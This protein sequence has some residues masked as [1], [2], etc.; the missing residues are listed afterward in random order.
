MDDLGDLHQFCPQVAP[1]FRESRAVRDD[2]ADVISPARVPTSTASSGTVLALVVALAVGI[3]GGV[4]LAF[5][6]EHLD[7]TVRSAADLEE[8]AGLAA[9]A[10]IPA[11]RGGRRRIAAPRP[12]LLAGGAGL[13]H[14]AGFASSPPTG[15]LRRRRRR[16]CLDKAPFPTK[17][18]GNVGKSPAVPEVPLHMSTPRRRW[19]L[20]LLL[21]P[22]LLGAAACGDDGDSSDDASGDSSETSTDVPALRLGYFPNLTHAPALVGVEQGIFEDALEGE[23]TL[24]T[25]TF[26]AG[27]EAVEALFADALDATFIGPNPAINA[28]AQSDGAAVRIISGSTS[29]GAYLVVRDG[30]DAPEDLAGTT[31]A[32]PQLGNTQDVALRSW[33]KDEGYATDEAGGGD[34]SIEPQANGDAL[35]AFVAGDIDGAWVPEPWATRMVQEGSGHVLVDEG[36]LWPEGK[37]VTTHLIVRTEYLEENPEAVKAL[38]DGTVDAIDAANDDPEAAKE[39]AN[40]QLE[41][42]TDKPLDDAVIDA[43]WENLTFT[44]DPIATSLQKGAEDAEAVGLLDPVDLD[45]IYDLGPL[46]EVLTDK[47]Q[48]AVEDL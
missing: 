1:T 31:L 26:N 14:P 40:A 10:T 20:A 15:P 6:R 3:V 22:A 5:L 33:L 37:Y 43:A 47:G 32:S 36:D 23:A 11:A 7:D 16:G 46:N 25:S 27:P 38:L 24:E 48:T 18:V 41:E 8:A 34:V 44:A 19:W 12:R 9:L 28:Y 42:L 45:G 13:P 30:I 2:V 35:A 17:L 4:A 21:V 29:G 39:A